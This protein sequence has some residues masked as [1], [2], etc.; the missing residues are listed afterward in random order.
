MK[1]FVKKKNFSSLI[2]TNVR[3]EYVAMH[4]EFDFINEKQKIQNEGRPFDYCEFWSEEVHY[5]EIPKIEKFNV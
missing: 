4:V 1:T 2:V 3:V 5:K